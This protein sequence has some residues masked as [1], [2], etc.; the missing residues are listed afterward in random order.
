MMLKGVS[1]STVLVIFACACALGQ[2]PVSEL[3]SELIRADRQI[4]QAIAG[5]HPNM[6]ELN[7]AL[8]PD[9]VDVDSGVRHSRA[10][11]VEYLEGLTKF[12]FQY[13]N[14]HAYVLS[15][16]SGYVIAE[17]SYASVQNGKPATGKVLTTTVFSKDHGRWMAHLHTEMD[18]KAETP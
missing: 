16:T 7:R 4:W 10:E 15:P 3:Q 6:D 13:G 18:M 5:S 1:A 8:A 14:A 11:V 9:Y 2:D 12:S 17:L